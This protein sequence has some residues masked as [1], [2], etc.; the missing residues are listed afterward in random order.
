ME[1]HWGR[2][3][4]IV[5]IDGGDDECDVLEISISPEAKKPLPKE[6]LHWSKEQKAAMKLSKMGG[7]FEF[8][9]DSEVRIVL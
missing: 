8:E 3:D 9:H 5:Q 6:A 4:G 1:W 7:V 2:I